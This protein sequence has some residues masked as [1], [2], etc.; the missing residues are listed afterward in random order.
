MKFPLI[1]RGYGYN[2]ENNY[3]NTEILAELELNFYINFIFSYEQSK[4]YPNKKLLFSLTHLETQ[5]SSY[6]LNH[7]VH[8]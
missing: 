3:K 7:C 8:I 1:G 6:A 4:S 2:G 5:T